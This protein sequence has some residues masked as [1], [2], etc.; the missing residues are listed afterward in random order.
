MTKSLI[1]SFILGIFLISAISNLSAQV[2]HTDKL[3]E[4]L[5]EK[6]SLLFDVSFNTC[7]ISQ[8]ENLVSDNFEFY[9]DKAGITNSKAAF[10]SGIKNGLCKLD[11]KPRR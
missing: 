5:K 10:I 7:D 2:Q 6:D 3:Y 11:Y 8:F 1:K 9:H 4:T